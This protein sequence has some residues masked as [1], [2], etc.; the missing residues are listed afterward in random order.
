MNEADVVA[1][2]QAQRS[3][4]CDL[5]D[6]RKVFVT[7]LS[8]EAGG[9]AFNENLTRGQLCVKQV[10]GWE[11]VTVGDLGIGTSEQS[12]EPVAFTPVV[13]ESIIFDK[14]EWLEQIAQVIIDDYMTRLAEHEENKKK[15]R[16]GLSTKA[17]KSSSKRARPG[18][19]KRK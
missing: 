11:G 9:V 6:G 4:V 10:T 1:A 13:F 8:Y 18:G 5:G 2:L 17:S 14:P 19:S 12:D 16:T 3:L 15:S 7:R